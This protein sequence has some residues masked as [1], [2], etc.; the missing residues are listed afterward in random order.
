MRHSEKILFKNIFPALRST[1]MFS[2]DLWG[3]YRPY[4]A[5]YM[6]GLKKWTFCIQFEDIYLLHAE[7]SN[8]IIFVDSLLATVLYVCKILAFYRIVLLRMTWKKGHFFDNFQ[9]TLP[10]LKIK[11][12][13]KKALCLKT[14]IFCMQSDWINKNGFI[15]LCKLAWACR[16]HLWALYHFLSSS[17][18]CWKTHFR[19]ECK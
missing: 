12:N 19:P 5:N 7:W 9:A 8:A 17:T 15:L 1:L 14:Y 6:G 4:Y 10:Y 16:S 11:K 3:L 13:P 2:V 18:V